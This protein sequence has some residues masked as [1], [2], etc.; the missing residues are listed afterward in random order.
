LELDGLSV[1]PCLGHFLFAKMAKQCKKILRGT[2]PDRDV[3]TIRDLVYYQ[4]AKI[5][6]KSAF[7]ASDGAQGLHSFY[8]AGAR[9]RQ[10]VL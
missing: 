2:M 10:E 6:A 5:I 1:G 3:A 9:E 4:Y 8:R 7:A